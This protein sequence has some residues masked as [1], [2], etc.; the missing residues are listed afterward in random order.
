MALQ[1]VNIGAAPNDGTGDPIRTAFGKVNANFSELYPDLQG[2][3][4]YSLGAGAVTDLVLGAANAFLTSNGTIPA[5]L[6]LANVIALLQGSGGTAA[7]VGFKG[8][9]INPQ[10]GNYTCSISDNG[11]LILHPSGSGAGTTKTIPSNAS[12]PY[13]PGAIIGFAN[14]S[15]NPVTI[16]IASDTLLWE[17]VGTAGSRT[18]S[19]YGR[20]F[21]LKLTTTVWMFG[22]SGVS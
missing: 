21:A 7:A 15:S 19:Q 1:P 3:M 6:T 5:W 8:V 10:T 9:P 22:G 18:L 17:G 14:L 16:A 13:D 12:V 4:S 11:R 20:A 2:S